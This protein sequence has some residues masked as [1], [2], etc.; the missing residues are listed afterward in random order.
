MKM[1]RER[2]FLADNTASAKALRQECQ[3]QVM[4]RCGSWSR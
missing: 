4:A 1:S 3:E 2:A